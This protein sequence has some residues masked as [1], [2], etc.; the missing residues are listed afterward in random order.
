MRRIGGRNRLDQ[1]SCIG[2]LVAEDLARV[3]VSTIW[4][5]DITPTRSQTFSTTAMAI[6]TRWRIPPESWCGYCQ[7]R[8]SGCCSRAARNRQRSSP[9]AAEDAGSG[10]HGCRPD[11]TKPRSRR[12]HHIPQRSARAFQRRDHFLAASAG[13]TAEDMPR[14]D[15]LQDFRAERAVKVD[16]PLHAVPQTKKPRLPQA[17]V[18]MG[19]R[20]QT[21][22]MGLQQTGSRWSASSC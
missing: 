12:R 11:G 5:R 10:R 16:P 3:P 2:V 4:P 7:S 1:P 8:R 18:R 21:A 9:E 17:P 22:A 6:I 20:G 14:V 19:N 15:V 13:D